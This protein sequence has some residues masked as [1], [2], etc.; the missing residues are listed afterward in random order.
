M[1]GAAP[2]PTGDVLRSLREGAREGA[3]GEDIELRA[4]TPHS[5]PRA[6]LAVSPA[7]PVTA[8]R[9]EA[10]PEDVPAGI[11]L[12]RHLDHEVLTISRANDPTRA[13]A[14]GGAILGV[15]GVIGIILAFDV[16]DLLRVLILLGLVAI[17]T[18]IGHTVL[19]R[20][21]TRRPVVLRLTPGRISVDGKVLAWE[22]IAEVTRTAGSRGSGVLLRA[23]SGAGV[24][25]G[26]DLRPGTNDF[27]FTRIERWWRRAH[28]GARD[29]EARAAL[30]ALRGRGDR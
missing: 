1:S 11:L 24:A 21:A 6:S 23:T 15:V 30:D 13:L 12:T 25:I 7:T 10:A 4:P 8:P 20:L 14:L 27:V 9:E 16:A 29:D 22:D 18:G 2:P 3:A 5:A 28:L 26:G 19:R 17:A